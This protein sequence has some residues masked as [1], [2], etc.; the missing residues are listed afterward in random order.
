MTP[1]RSSSVFTSIVVLSRYIPVWIANLLL[2][3]VI[4]IAAPLTIS[5]TSFSTTLPLVSFLAIASLGQMLV[6]MTGGIDLSTPHVM[7]LAA[8]ITVG[9]GAGSD[10]RLV[11][12]IAVA[13]GGSMLIG[14]TNGFLVGVLRLN[15]LII[16][17][18]AGQGVRG[19]TIDYSSYVANEAAVPN[20]LSTWAT[21]QVLGVS[22]LFWVGIVVAIILMLFLRYSVPGRRFRLC[23]GRRAVRAGRRLARR[24]HQEPHPRP[25]CVVPAGT[26]CGGCDRRGISHRRPGERPFDLRGRV[27]PGTV[28]GLAVRGLWVR[29]HRRHGRLRRSHH[30]G[31]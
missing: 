27:L 19:L 13:I 20:N 23:R 2:I 1:N 15:P 6:I 9:V 8:M 31:G 28:H 25:G 30:Q 26:H 24:V 7:T 14:L 4:L 12:A 11:L 22:I 21:T 3:I 10:D 16:T 29:D 18:A 5:Q 17:L